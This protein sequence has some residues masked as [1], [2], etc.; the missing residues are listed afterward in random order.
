MNQVFDVLIA[1]AGPGGCAVAL[2]LKS[3]A[4][5]LRICLVDRASETGS[6]I[7]E[8]A[9]PHLRPMLE[10]L[11]LWAAFQA[12]GHR[13][14]YRSRSSWGASEQDG[15]EFLEHPL[16]QGWTLDR[17]AF[18]RFLLG[19]AERVVDQRLIG[20]INAIQHNPDGLWQLD[21]GKGTPLA[22]AKVVVDAT[23]RAAAICRSLGERPT[24]HDKLIGYYASVPCLPGSEA[25]VL[26]ETRP[27]GW[28]YTAQLPGVRRVLAFMSDADLIRKDMDLG[29]KG[30]TDMLAETRHICHV[31]ASEAPLVAKPYPAASQVMRADLPDTILTVGDAA[32]CFDPIASSGI[33]KAL[34]AGIFASYAITDYLQTSQFK[35]LQDYRAYLRREWNIFLTS[36]QKYYAREQ[37]FPQSPFW[38]RRQLPLAEN[39]PGHRP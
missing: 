12:E 37:Q 9:S 3:H 17:V 6:E 11:G 2:S 24:R 36:W 15:V 27:E 13:P 21:S 14:V 31:L 23:G 22:R 28:W 39:A 10:Q 5:H 19:A 38:A 25:G 4:P 16:G 29:S 33:V 18:N 34:R 32:A 1:G 7:G 26:L 20:Q 35:P 30:F 8:A